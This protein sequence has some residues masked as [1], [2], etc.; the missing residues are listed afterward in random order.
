[1]KQQDMFQTI[2]DE[3]KTKLEWV[4]GIRSHDTRN[5]IQYTAGF[6]GAQTMPVEEEMPDKNEKQHN[7][8]IYFVASIV[9]LF[10]TT[11]NKQRFYIG[12]DQE[13]ISVAVS[14]V[15]GEFIASAEM[16]LVPSIHVWERRSLETLSV[17]KGDHASGVH[18]MSF[19]LDNKFLVTCGITNP[20]AVIIYDWRAG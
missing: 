12:H 11:V 15:G 19:T 13:V 4:Y 9:I 10:N 18:L 17:I 3:L 2:P 14:T 6:L 7:E 1:M 20:S 8:L 16:A 5:S